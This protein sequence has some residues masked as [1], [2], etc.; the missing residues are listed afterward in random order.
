MLPKFTDAISEVRGNVVGVLTARGTPRSPELTGLLALDFA[1]F[2]IVPL[3][4]TMRDINGLVRLKG[5]TLVIDSLVG[6]SRGDPG[7][8]GIG[9]PSSPPVVRSGLCRRTRAC[10]HDR[11]AQR[12]RE[13]SYRGTFYAGT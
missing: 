10:S 1:S 7:A 9:S 4:V 3:G 6:N 8:R 5:D 12:R 11:A 2:R 13:T